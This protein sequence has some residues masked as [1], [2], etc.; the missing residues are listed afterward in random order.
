V[1]HFSKNLLGNK[2]LRRKKLC[3][4]QGKNMATNDFFPSALL[5]RGKRTNFYPKHVDAQVRFG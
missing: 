4:S 3:T 5:G 2:E 1:R